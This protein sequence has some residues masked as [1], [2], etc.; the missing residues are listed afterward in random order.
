MSFQ[1]SNSHGGSKVGQGYKCRDLSL[2]RTVKCTG[3]IIA[4][5]KMMIYQGLKGEYSSQ[6]EQEVQMDG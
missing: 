3:D 1:I 2:D 4:E 5:I 6:R